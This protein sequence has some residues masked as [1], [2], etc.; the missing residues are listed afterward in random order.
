MNSC[1]FRMP[2]PGCVA[3]LPDPVDQSVSQG[4]FQGL[5]YRSELIRIILESFGMYRIVRGRR[6]FCWSSSE[7]KGVVGLWNFFGARGPNSAAPHH[8]T[9]CKNNG[10]TNKSV[11]F[12][13][14]AIPQNKTSLNTGTARRENKPILRLP[15]NQLVFTLFLYFSSL[16]VSFFD[17]LILTFFASPFFACSD[18]ELRKSEVSRPSILWVRQ[19]AS[20]SPNIKSQS[21][22][23]SAVVRK[24][25]PRLNRVLWFN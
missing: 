1:E 8:F 17:F 7:S 22:P 10:K 2:W 12:S 16:S 20:S 14:A 24:P 9:S 18:L 11:E 5:H 15:P 6:K 23:I 19:Q 13:T 25:R 4:Q 21:Q 3:W